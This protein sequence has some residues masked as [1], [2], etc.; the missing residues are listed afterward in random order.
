[1]ADIT[2]SWCEADV[3][4]MSGA[5]GR[6]R[7]D[8]R[9]RRSPA[10][11]AP[12]VQAPVS[13]PSIS[14]LRRSSGLVTAR[15]VLG[16]HAGVERGR[17]ELGM[18]EQHLDDADVDVLLEQVGG[19][20][21]AQR[22]GRDALLDA[23]RLGGLVDGAVELARRQR[24]DRLRPGNSQPWG[25]ITPRRLPSRHHSRSSSSSCGDSIALRSLRPLPCSTRISM[26]VLSM[27]PTLS[28]AT[29]D[30]RRPA[31]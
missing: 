5:T 8:G 10:R 23:G 20:A 17:V 25:S 30:T 15:I 22:M 6:H 13:S 9:C 24:L 26:R 19:K 27:S 3:A 11:R 14:S 2:L 12:P 16:R 28:A 31:P 18:S 21:V 29:S 7:A 4:G 1:M